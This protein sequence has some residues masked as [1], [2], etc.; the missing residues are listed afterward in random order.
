MASRVEV[1]AGEVVV[2]VGLDAGSK[3]PFFVVNDTDPSYRYKNPKFGSCFADGHRM[4]VLV[5]NEG[6]VIPVSDLVFAG[7]SADKCLECGPY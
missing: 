5:R 3:A 7:C 1:V 6:S 2:A 4:C